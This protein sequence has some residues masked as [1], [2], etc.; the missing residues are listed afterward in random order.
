MEF[1][2]CFFPEEAVKNMDE[3]DNFISSPKSKEE[4]E[5]GGPLEQQEHDTS[6]KFRIKEE[7]YLK[8]DDDSRI[9]YKTSMT[10]PANPE[11]D[12]TMYKSEV[13]FI[14]KSNDTSEY[15]TTLYIYPKPEN[16]PEEAFIALDEDLVDSVAKTPIIIDMPM[17]KGLD[18]EWTWSR[19]M[20][21]ALAQ[22]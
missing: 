6:M 10:I 8:P 7:V 18:E 22:H 9:H 15:S 4:D 19:K 12:E 17:G 13:Y 11:I 14:P 5:K 21:A 20:Y 16:E 2:Y 1:L 3:Q